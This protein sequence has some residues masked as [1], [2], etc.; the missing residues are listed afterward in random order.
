MARSGT[1]AGATWT[2]RN[3]PAVGKALLVCLVISTM[4]HV[5]VV[6][7]M[8][9]LGGAG[10]SAGGENGHGGGGGHTVEI[11]VAGP[12]I[13]DEP[14]PGLP[15]APAPAPEPIERDTDPDPAHV[16][17]SE[18][19][20]Q[21]EP[22][23]EPEL[24]PVP[25]DDPVQLPETSTAETEPPSDA[26][27]EPDTAEQ[28][29][30]GTGAEDSSG[31]LEGPEGVRDLILG[32]A[33]LLPGSVA[34]QRALLPRPM[35]CDDPVRGEWRAHKFS[36]L[37]GDW[38]RFTLRIERHGNRLSGTI[39]SRMW[40][41]N[42][43]DSSPPPCTIGSHDYTV[44]MNAFGHVDGRRITFGANSYRIVAAHCPSPFFGYNPDHFS[45]EIDP[46][47]QEFQSVNND[48]GRDIDAPYLFRRVSCDP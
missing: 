34:E 3:L 28:V 37:Y 47:R 45:G 2:R 30:S 25:H 18:P 27:A 11:A 24:P 48:G 26:P 40:K 31:R 43:F 36:P 41:G 10:G 12:A 35:Q 14:Q 21:P 22:A 29:A 8:S 23:A 9:L 13:A 4:V 16:P 19:E 38:A 7:T 20:P 15:A 39:T 42:R 5:T 17:R 44:R 46:E 6:A 1:V 32:S 33:G